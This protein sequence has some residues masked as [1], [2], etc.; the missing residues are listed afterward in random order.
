MYQAYG[1]LPPGVGFDWETAAQ[2]LK[3]RFPQMDVARDGER[4]A[5]T[6]GDWE[7]HLA[8]N[9]GPE[10]L[11][12]SAQIAEGIGGQIDG[13][14]IARCDRRVEVSSDVQDPFL[15]HFSDFQAVIEVLQSFEGV[16]VVDPRE[17][18]LM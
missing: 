16:I 4:I 3:A 9:S 18:S 15:E 12:E 1:L 6:S 13:A 7:I 11:A 17:P 5:V 2:R 10:V 14:G 8:M